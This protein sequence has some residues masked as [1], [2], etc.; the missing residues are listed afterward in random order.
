MRRIKEMNIPVAKPLCDMHN[1]I[2]Y[3]IK[4]L[5]SEID[6]RHCHALEHLINHA[7]SPKEIID[8]LLTKMVR[9]TKIETILRLFCLFSVTQSGLK[10]DSF[11]LLKRAFLLQYGYQEVATLCN[12][13]VA[14]LFRLRD[15]GL[16]WAA[17]KEKFELIEEDINIQNPKSYSYV[18]GGLKPLSI[19]FI[20]TLF[21]KRGFK[22]MGNKCKSHCS[23]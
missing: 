22:G 14:G 3:Y 12:L 1:N 2:C 5:N 7:E 4:K 23:I 10:Q 6:N 15:K 20:E 11:E 19:R 13:E 21:I 17:V 18:F 8:S 9:Q 16:D